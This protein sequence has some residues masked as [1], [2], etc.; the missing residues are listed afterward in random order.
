MAQ[1][2]SNLF[3]LGSTQGW[4]YIGQVSDIWG[5]LL[6]TLTACFAVWGFFNRAAFKRY[7]TRITYSDVGR[8][9][10]EK[11]E[12]E[13]VI[14][15]VSHATVPLMV[16]EKTQPKRIALIAT[17][18]SK[19]EAE[20]IAAQ[21][22]GRETKIFILDDKDDPAEAKA[23]VNKAIVHWTD[24]AP[25]RIA[26]DVTGGTT[27]MSIG[28]FMAAQQAGVI[29]IYMKSEYDKDKKEIKAGSSHL[30]CIAAS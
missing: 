22:L 6:G 2:L 7:L 28:A 23:T 19:V 20:I 10:T 5:A 4:Q 27:P 8:A 21:A 30:I 15:T 29:T 17:E 1:E 11:Q 14:F 24:I 9:I 13:L 26:V 12:Y 3:G 25:E 16:I 18:G